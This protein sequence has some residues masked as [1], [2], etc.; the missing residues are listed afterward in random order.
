MDSSTSNASA[1]S[2]EYMKATVG[3]PQPVPQTASVPQKPLSAL[4]S[5]TTGFIKVIA[6]SE[7]LDTSDIDKS[8]A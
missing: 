4:T 3:L 1:F 6:A 7:P 5:R 8:T 2:A